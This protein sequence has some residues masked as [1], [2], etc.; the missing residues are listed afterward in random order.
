MNRRELVKLGA[1]QAAMVAVPVT[2][3]VVAQAAAK[4]GSPSNAK[5]LTLSN[6]Q[7]AL[8]VTTGA[9][10][11]C[12][13]VHRPTG[14]VLADGSYFYSFGTPVFSQVQQAGSSLVLQGSIPGTGMTIQHRFKAD[15][16]SPWIE[17][18]LEFNNQGE[19]PLDLHDAR[20]GFVLPV[21]LQGKQ[22]PASLGRV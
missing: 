13:L 9:G 14:A 6:T 11:E 7:F 12:K 4:S 8:T 16:G 15:A 22:V 21:P 20:A 2:G 3:S 1:V 17:E 19:L 18:E 5:T 10:L